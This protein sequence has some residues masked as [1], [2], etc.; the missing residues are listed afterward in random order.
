MMSEVLLALKCY[1]TFNWAWATLLGQET[2]RWGNYEDN[3]IIRETNETNIYL[4]V[5]AKCVR[6]NLVVQA[7]E[8][9][10]N[11]FLPEEVKRC[12]ESNFGNKVFLLLVYLQNT[13]VWAK[14]MLCHTG[15]NKICRAN[16]VGTIIFYF[17]HHLHADYPMIIK[18]RAGL[19]GKTW[20]PLIMELLSSSA[21]QYVI[22]YFLVC[23]KCMC[24]PWALLAEGSFCLSVGLYV[25]LSH[26]L[27]TCPSVSPS[28]CPSICL[29]NPLIVPIGDDADKPNFFP[30]QLSVLLEFWNFTGRLY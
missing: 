9:S 23:A 21:Y 7:E 26:F 6:C 16:I 15:L 10:L 20:W 29:S 8:S 27:L 13:L 11:T 4:L 5:W 22:S 2:V 18:I 19:A 28:I 17:S 24:C 12:G 3:I 14:H 25:P 30:L 1:N